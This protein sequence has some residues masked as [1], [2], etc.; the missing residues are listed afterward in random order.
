MVRDAQAHAAEDQAARQAVDSRNKADQMVYMTE[1]TLTENEEKLSDATKAAV[2]DA[3][4]GTKKALEGSDAATIEAACK[5][6]EQ[7][8]HQLAAE[9]YKAQ[10]S[11][12]DGTAG[13]PDPARSTAAADDVIDAEVV[14]QEKGA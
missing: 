5:K 11:P 1:K 13:G 14:D 4:E 6:L 10:D 3:I 8:S 7:S 9:L 12:G 2:R